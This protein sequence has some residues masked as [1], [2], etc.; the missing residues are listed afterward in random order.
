ELD[1]DGKPTG[2][3]R[4]VQLGSPN[5]LRTIYETNLRQAM[6][7]GRWER[8]ERTAD[9]RPYLRYVAMQDGNTRDEHAQ[10]H[11]T[12]LA[13][14]DPWWQTH[15]PPNGW[16]CRCKIQQLSERDLARYGL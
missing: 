5:R 7:A 8:I 13:W 12:V 6:A 2:R 9:R 15:A 14:D 10:W 4:E 1:S 11:N 3:M 16:G